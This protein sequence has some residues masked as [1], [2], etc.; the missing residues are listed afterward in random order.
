MDNLSSASTTV[1]YTL[2]S[3]FSLFFL[4]LFIWQI[5]ILRGKSVP[6]PDGSIDDWH[7]QKLLYGMAFADIFLACPLAFA[8]IILC[9]LNVKWGFHILA[10]ESFFFIWINLATTVTSLRFHKPKI[11]F[12]WIIVFPFGSFLGLAFLIWI[13]INYDKIF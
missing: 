11:T 10:L 12:S 2:I 5:K 9:L 1:F 8:G 7:E 4:I 3:L 6:N 13:F